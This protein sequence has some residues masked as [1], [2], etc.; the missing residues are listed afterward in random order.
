MRRGTVGWVGGVGGS[1]SFVTAGKTAGSFVWFWRHS[2]TSDERLIGAAE[3]N[4]SL[5]TL[6]VGGEICRVRHLSWGRSE[7][8]WLNYGKFRKPAFERKFRRLHFFLIVISLHFKGAINTM[9]GGTRL[10]RPV[11]S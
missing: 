7:E 8:G 5:E 2:D 11:K 3:Q 4:L 10:S 9:G 6:V 1:G